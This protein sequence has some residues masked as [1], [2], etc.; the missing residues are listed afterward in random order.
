MRGLTT[1]TTGEFVTIDGVDYEFHSLVEPEGERPDKSDDLQFLNA[2]HRRVKIFTPVEFLAAYADGRVRL[3]RSHAHAGDENGEGESAEKALRRRWRHFWVCAF[4]SDPVPLSSKKLASFVERYQSQ[5]PDP[6]APP[7]PETLRKWIRERGSRGDRR[8]RQMG[9]RSRRLTR[10]RPLHPEIQALWT[11]SSDLYWSNS[12]IT[13]EDVWTDVRAKLLRLNQVRMAEGQEPLKASRTT[14]WRHL[15]DE[16]TY[17]NICARE[18]RHV[19]DRRFKSVKGSLEAKR[20]GDIAIV[21]HKRMDVHVVD[22]TGQF[23]LGRPWLAVLI[24]VKSRMVLGFT[25]TFE[26]PSVLSV[27]ACVRMALRGEPDLQSK[28]PGVRGDWVSFGV[29]RTI[30]A[31]NAWENT[32]SSFQDACEDQG[33]SIEWAPVR[34]P[35]YKGILERFFST[36]DMQLVHKLPGAV[37]AAPHILAQKRIDPRRDANITLAQLR[38]FIVRYIVDDYATAW[39]ETL[40][41]APLKVW[42]D[43]VDTDGIELAHD[44]ASVESAMGTLV[45]DRKLT[46]EGVEFMGLQYRSD[47]VDGLLADLLPREAKSSRPGTATVKMKYHPEDLSRIFV[48]NEVRK[49]YVALPCVQAR[50]ADGLSLRLHEMVR[51]QQRA[52]HAAFQSEHEACLNKAALLSAIQESYA[53]ASGRDRKRGARLTT[54]G[55]SVPSSKRRIAVHAVSARVGADQPDKVSVRRRQPRQRADDHAVVAPRPD[56]PATVVDP[57]ATTDWSTAIANSK[58]RINDGV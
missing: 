3:H 34:R 40:N 57:F 43:R 4:D 26:D 39:H 9:D 29:P 16:A 38:T 13:F 14:L 24:D 56:Q 25:L 52:D 49:T 53:D 5:Q 15:Q 19:A 45:R 46:R 31:D 10:R 37:T 2:R 1:F 6:I 27:M 54:S 55:P 12:K 48:W 47:A 36:L 20:L 17:A 32:G 44:L 18:G 21:D 35:E 22:D 41:A 23:V 50:Y 51:Q 42:Q 8:P 7:S 33:I 28:Y 11:A 30:L 58:A